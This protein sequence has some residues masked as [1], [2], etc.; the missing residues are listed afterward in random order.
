MADEKFWHYTAA[1]EITRLR[2]Q[3]EELREETEALKEELGAW[4]NGSC[5]LSGEAYRFREALTRIINIEHAT[6]PEMDYPQQCEI[7]FNFVVCASIIAAEALTGQQQNY[8]VSLLAS[9]GAT[10]ADEIPDRQS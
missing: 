1:E 3:N 10:G 6:N 2:H 4:Q 5:D 9:Q 8:P 7:L